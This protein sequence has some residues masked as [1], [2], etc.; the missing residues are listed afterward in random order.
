MTLVTRK[1]KLQLR[2]YAKPINCHASVRLAKH[3]QP[4]VMVLGAC[5]GGAESRVL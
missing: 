1:D 3:R 4:L 2:P 5:S